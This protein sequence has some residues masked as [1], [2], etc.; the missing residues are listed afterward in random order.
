M[1][2]EEMRGLVHYAHRL[3]AGLTAAADLAEMR[4]DDRC[5]PAEAEAIRRLVGELA[6]EV[7]ASVDPR[8]SRVR[9]PLC[10]HP[11]PWSAPEAGEPEATT[12]QRMLHC[13]RCGRSWSGRMRRVEVEETLARLASLPGGVRMAEEVAA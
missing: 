11:T 3:E 8:P 12:V 5:S 10:A 4:G 1:T 7:G 9:C 2:I 13:G 6:A